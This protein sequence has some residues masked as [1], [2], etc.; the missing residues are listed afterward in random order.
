MSNLVHV[1][2]ADVARAAGLSNGGASYALRAHPSIPSSTVEK[3]RRI[4]AEL[5]YRPDMRISSLMATIRRSRPLST[6]ETI[7]F[8][9][10]NTPKRLD[11][12]P[13]HLQHYA[14]II[15]Q[16]AQQRAEQL[17]CGIEQF[18][19]DDRDMRPRRL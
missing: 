4:A 6:R 7:A 19:L 9:W 15:L 17:G 1:T 14:R 2:L 13:L 5:G 18:W 16:G 12:L 11:K 3:V 8:V 10:I